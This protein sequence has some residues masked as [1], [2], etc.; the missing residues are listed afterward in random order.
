VAGQMGNANND[1]LGDSA[2]DDLPLR[3]GSHKLD[4]VAS[5]NSGSGLWLG[6]CEAAKTLGTKT[7]QISS[8][9][10]TM[11]FL[12]RADPQHVKSS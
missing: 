2:A 5:S 3:P 8:G 11:L 4:V 1:F 6:Q 9:S 7:V 12:Y 10:P